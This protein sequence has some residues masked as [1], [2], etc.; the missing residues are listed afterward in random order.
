MI[1]HFLLSWTCSCPGPTMG[2]WGTLNANVRDLPW[3]GPRWSK[4]WNCNSA[5]SIRDWER[6]HIFCGRLGFFD[7]CSSKIFAWSL[8]SPPAVPFPA[9]YF[10]H[11]Y[12]CSFGHR[13]NTHT[14]NF[15]LSGRWYSYLDISSRTQ[16]GSVYRWTYP[17]FAVVAADPL[18]VVFVLAVIGVYLLTELAIKIVVVVLIAVFAEEAV[19]VVLNSWPY[20]F[21]YFFGGA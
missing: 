15:Y 14:K 20:F 12:F 19:L 16:C 17:A 18:I 7:L 3:S 5:E 8:A 11:C 1:I 9:S 4:V 2:L 6:F 13:P 21:I 10:S